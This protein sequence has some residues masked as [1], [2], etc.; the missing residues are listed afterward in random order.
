MVGLYDFEEGVVSYLAC[1]FKYNVAIVVGVSETPFVDTPL[2]TNFVTGDITITDRYDSEF[3]DYG[4]ANGTTLTA[5]AVAEDI[6]L[7]VASSA[8]MVVDERVSVE[9]DNSLRHVT[10]VRSI[11]SATEITIADSL[12]SAA[13]IGN[14]VVTASQLEN[15]T[16][17]TLSED[18]KIAKA[19]EIK[20]NSS[21]LAGAGFVYQGRH[22]PLTASANS[23]LGGESSIDPSIRFA[24]LFTQFRTDRV[25]APLTV[26][27]ITN[28]NPAV[29]T[30]SDANELLS[31]DAVTLSGVGGMTEVNGQLFLVGPITGNSFELRIF[32][33]GAPT[34]STG[35]GVYTS[36]GTATKLD[37]AAFQAVLDIDGVAYIVANNTDFLNMVFNASQ[38][39]SY[40][41]GAT[42]QTGLLTQVSL[43]PNTQAA[44][45]AI[46]DTR[47]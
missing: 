29:I 46:V 40:I 45:D 23:D 17:G 12:P 6:S 14:N 25:V 35:F 37:A 22:F 32:P 30:V 3:Y 36:G 19:S 15:T 33:D 42:G 4:T 1:I 7:T 47:T 27:G 28:A 11:D 41:F 18:F 43:S 10:F 2:A 9:L 31:Y 34:D 21:F 13:A 39:R 26:T 16:D 5:A 44:M 24:T 20:N 38:R 8:E